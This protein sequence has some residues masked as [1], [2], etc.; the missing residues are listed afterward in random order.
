MSSLSSW[1]IDA[2]VVDADARAG[3]I[4]A[5]SAQADASAHS[6][7]D[8]AIPGAIVNRA[9]GTVRRFA[10]RY[11]SHPELRGRMGMSAAGRREHA[12]A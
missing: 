3:I 6:I 8:L 9:A 2:W 4:I 10:A 7:L 12:D 1:S 5:R 11:L